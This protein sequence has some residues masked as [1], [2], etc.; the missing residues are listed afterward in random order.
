MLL[1]A[2]F[3]STACTLVSGKPTCTACALGWRAPANQCTKCSSDAV[4]GPNQYC[5]KVT[6]N[7]TL[8]SATNARW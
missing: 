3:R 7:P 6:G 8:C 2:P 5:D 1:L 4:V